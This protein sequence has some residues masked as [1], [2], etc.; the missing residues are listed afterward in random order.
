MADVDSFDLIARLK[1]RQADV[2]VILITGHGDL[3]TAIRAMREGAFDFFT[4]PI[5]LEDLSPRYNAPSVIKPCGA[6]RTGSRSV[7]SR[8][9]VPARRR[10]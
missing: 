2:E 1:D 5:K 7:W 3:N 4:K 9:Y 6:K 10:I 8:C